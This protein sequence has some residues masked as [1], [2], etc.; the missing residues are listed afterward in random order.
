MDDALQNTGLHEPTVGL[1][2]ECVSPPPHMS[3]AYLVHYAD[4]RYTSP[5]MWDQPQT[6]HTKADSQRNSL[7]VRRCIDSCQ[8]LLKCLWYILRGVIDQK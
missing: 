6:H 7:N 4:H 3:A 5:G 8:Y 1:H 2:A